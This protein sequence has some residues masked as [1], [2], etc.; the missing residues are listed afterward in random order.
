METLF[1][2]NVVHEASRSAEEIDPI[3]LAAN[4]QFQRD[5]ADI[6]NGV[7]RRKQLKTLARN[8]I[9][10]SRFVSKISA[11]P[12]L[13]RLEDSAAVVDDL[14]EAGKTTRSD[15]GTGL[16]TVLGGD[17][18][19]FVTTAQLRGRINKIK[20]SILAIKLS[21]PDHDRPVHRLVAILRAFNL[22]QR[23]VDNSAFP[24]NAAILIAN[25]R[26]ALL[27]PGAVMPTQ[28]PS[29]PRRKP[30]PLVNKL[31]ALAGVHDRLD[32]AIGELRRI[33]LGE[34]SVTPQK[35]S[36]QRLPPEKFRPLKLFEEELKIR[37]VSLQAT[38]LSS[39]ANITRTP[40]RGD[41][42]TIN[43]GDLGT[44]SQAL[45]NF[46]SENVAAETAGFSL[47][48][49]AR[50][51]MMGRADFQPVVSG[52]VGL[53]LSEATQEKLSRETRQVMKEHGLSASEPIARSVQKLTAVR[54]Q[55]YEQ[56]Q[57]LVQ[58]VAQKSFKKI[59]N[60][61]VA[62]TANPVPLIY[63]MSPAK[64]LG[65]IPGFLFDPAAGVPVT[66]ADIKPSGV[67][68]LLLVKQQLKGYER[69]EV[70][71][72]AN[73]LKG[74]K[75]DRT[76]RV[77]LETESVTF[78]E[79]EK[80]TATEQ[81]LETTDRFEMRRESESSLQ[82]ETAIKGSLMVKGKYG[83]TVEFKAEGEAS[84]KRKSQESE[85]A[86]NEVAR[87]VTQKASEKITER[88]LRRESLRI[89]RQMEEINQHS[90]DNTAGTGHISGVY[91]WVTKVYEAQVFNYGPRTVYD[92]MIPEPGAF[93]LEAF[94]RRRTA[95]IEL[96]KP[97]DFEITP[98]MLNEDNYQTYVT[99][100]GA[101]D[102]KPPPEPFVTE[103][104]DFN[105]GG[106]DKDQEFTNSTRIKIPDGYEAVRATMGA[107]VAVWDNWSVDA[108]IGQR[109]H[110]FQS[111]SGWVWSTALDEETNSVPLAMV[112]DRVGDV[113][114]AVEVI[115]EATD[116]A[117]DL[118]RAE[119]HAKLINAY[120][121]RL[122]DYEAKLAE[123]EA[124]APEEI[125]S[126]PS[127][128]NRAL[129]IDEVKRACISVLT[130]QHFEMFDAIDK[131]AAGLPEIN[132]TE[133]QLEG[134][135]ARF[136]EQ[137]FEWQNLSWMAYSYFWGRKSTWL[138]KVVIEDDDAD[139]E[140]FLKAGYIRVQIPIRPGFVDAVDHFRI[141]GD[142]WQ[143]GSL[144]AIS[145]ATYLPIA[146]EIAEKLG[147]PGNELPV[148]EP[149]EV[150]VPTTLVKLRSDDQL[151]RW[152][153]QADG[154]WAEATG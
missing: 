110:R 69:A 122:A 94:R 8:Y 64:I 36:P 115:C 151:P 32:Q 99:V 39:G 95:A 21:P 77:R 75:K 139:F 132:F 37:Q 14:I 56:A 124:E 12:K 90:F 128:R 109:S 82:E 150:R 54:R 121:A 26:R 29:P 102:V 40:A 42:Q 31:E 18:G 147:R 85:K 87:E 88:V 120:R 142:T 118:W 76:H 108:V 81:V 105:T 129:M 92:F 20:D 133:T 73:M 46:R 72:I 2:F 89:N 114:I 65:F 145:D 66:H 119:T 140:A 55:V 58:P 43:I 38:L 15:L 97:L 67:M 44:V 23:F 138:D 19:T 68:D 62:I 49:G 96:E 117:L 16:T 45:P 125:D 33:R 84:W 34:F 57:A 136:F 5:A 28:P 41:Q 146:E 53:R 51:A 59:G 13:Q 153:K 25:Q 60:T 91:Q 106:E 134:P 9:K 144:P 50:I 27:I 135:Y 79:T 141:F 1:R 78:T 152:Q 80:T 30:A 100:Y 127:E 126:G 148:G 111:G 52:L 131:D 63:S 17:P 71:H 154:T 86:S 35:S 116:R 143:G 107:V 112:T 149:W 123:L 10:S 93:L 74:E 113:A 104:Y 6:P 47:G 3:P 11:S 48:R 83:P 130:E 61:T 24:E 70:S 7:N 98:D 103:S 137:A 101:T 22:V 4:T